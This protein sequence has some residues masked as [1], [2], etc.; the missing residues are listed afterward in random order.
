MKWETARKV[1]TVLG[2]LYVVALIPASI[3]PSWNAAPFRK[4][5]AEITTLA[6]ATNLDSRIK[7]A[8]RAPA[9]LRP[10][11]G[12]ARHVRVITVGSAGKTLN[13]DEVNCELYL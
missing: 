12:S 5:N 11:M 13:V 2:I 1:L 3:R 4:P 10:L 9:L 8:C 7:D 6:G